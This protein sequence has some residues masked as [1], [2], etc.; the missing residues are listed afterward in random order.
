MSWMLCLQQNAAAMSSA[1]SCAQQHTIV[2]PIAM[3]SNEASPDTQFCFGL[4]GVIAPA[5]EWDPA[6]LLLGRSKAEVFQWRESEL[7]HG[8]IAMLASVGFLTQEIFH[9]LGENLP[10]LAQVYHLPQ[11]L[12]FSIPT[13]IGFCETARSQRWTGNEVIRNVLPTSEDGGYLGSY[14]SD[15][16]Y[17]PGDIG[18]DPLDLKPKDPAELRSMQ[19][20]EL[21]HAR[22]AMVAAAGFIGQE[23]VSGVTWGEQLRAL[24]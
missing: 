11:A 7:T 13:V 10:V 4:P 19:E 22:L 15:V 6:N 5:G 14:R 2:R 18:F 21:A 17:Y 12:W 9:P 1:M 23:V 16:G 8:R 24:Y 20:A 3:L